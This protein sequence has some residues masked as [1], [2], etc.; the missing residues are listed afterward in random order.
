MDLIPPL[1]LFYPPWVGCLGICVRAHTFAGHPIR[2]AALYIVYMYKAIFL[3]SLEF[4]IASYV[5]EWTTL[6]PLDI[7]MVAAAHVL[8]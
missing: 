8:C 6:P 3:Y 2:G 1:Y 5:L 4:S 7:V